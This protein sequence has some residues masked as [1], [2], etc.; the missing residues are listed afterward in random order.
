M[1]VYLCSLTSS[2]LQTLSMDQLN[3]MDAC[4]PDLSAASQA[5]IYLLVSF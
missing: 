2:D 3:T 1:L 4:D 5:A